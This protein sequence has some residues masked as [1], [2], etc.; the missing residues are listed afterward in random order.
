VEEQDNRSYYWQYY[1]DNPVGY[2]EK[3]P[4]PKRK[5][6]VV[7][8]LILLICIGLL[9]LLVCELLSRFNSGSSFSAREIEGYFELDYEWIYQSSRWHYGVD[10]SK[11]LYYYYSE[12]DRT[13]NYKEYVLNSND[14]ELMHN[15]ASFLELEAENKGWGEAEKV[16]FA[17]S[18]VQS[19]PYTDDKETTG[20]D[21]YPR[22]PVETMVEIGGD[23]EDTA[24]LFTS[25]V[26]EMGYGV[27]LLELEEDRHMAAGVLISQELVDS[28]PHQNRGYPLT[29]YKTKDGKI[30]AYCETTNVGWKLGEKPDDLVS[31]NARIIEISQ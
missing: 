27:A 2:E 1:N 5:N 14:D 8:V 13:S 9:G 30:F 23:C 31:S 7:T 10:V 16:S 24:I 28:W 19:L 26:R 20:Y 4:A 15:L 29:Y 3:P 11:D 17:L 6:I 25:I 12:K 21:E 18:F 22:Y